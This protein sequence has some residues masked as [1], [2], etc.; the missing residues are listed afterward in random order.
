M[1]KIKDAMTPGTDLAANKTAIDFLSAAAE[2]EAAFDRLL[3]FNKGVY[4]SG[5]EEVPLDSQFLAHIA[6]RV[7]CWIK[8][9]DGAIADKK[10]YHVARG[11]EPPEREE[12]DARDETTWPKDKNGKRLDPWVLQN[13]FPLEDLDSGEILIFVTPS[14]GGSIAVGDLTKAYVTHVKNGH[15]GQPI[16]SLQTKMMPTSDYGDIPRPAFRIVRWDDA[17]TDVPVVAE[18]S[19]APKKVHSKAEVDDDMADEIPF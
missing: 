11:E 14:V 3:K 5:G 6:T 16:V 2:K 9:V 12:L 7:K 8:F 15:V 17:A 4:E 1:S 13:Q 10:V 19:V 18:T